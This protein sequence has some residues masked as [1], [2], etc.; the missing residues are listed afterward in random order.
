[1]WDLS[2]GSPPQGPG[3]GQD[4]GLAGSALRGCDLMAG[5]PAVTATMLFSAYPD[6]ADCD[7]NA[8]LHLRVGN[9]GAAAMAHPCSSGSAY[10]YGPRLALAL[11][12][13]ANGDGQG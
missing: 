12:S 13:L 11:R 3:R 4:F 7:K 5:S 1:M 10:P 9:G 8:R 6:K 2:R